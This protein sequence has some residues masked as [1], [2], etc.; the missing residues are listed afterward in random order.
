MKIKKGIFIPAKKVE[1]FNNSCSDSVE[2]PNQTSIK[3]D[4][5]ETVFYGYRKG[6]C[7]SGGGN[8]NRRC[9]DGHLLQFAFPCGNGK[10]PRER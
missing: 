2:I 1:H 3:W 5:D 8:V 7:Y 6:G 10:L 4:N 9:P